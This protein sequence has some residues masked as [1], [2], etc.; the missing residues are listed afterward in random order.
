MV[1][2]TPMQ[3]V[4]TEWLI[5]EVEILDEI[6]V[7]LTTL[8]WTRRRLFNCLL[9][10]LSPLD[11]DFRQSQ[12]QYDTSSCNTPRNRFLPIVS[13]RNRQCAIPPFQIGGQPSSTSVPSKS[14]STP[15]EAHQPAQSL[16]P[17]YC[18]TAEMVS[19]E[20]L[21]QTLTNQIRLSTHYATLDK[22]FKPAPRNQSQNPST[23]KYIAKVSATPPRARN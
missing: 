23:D 13:N 7:T 10:I 16:P 18:E 21:P 5:T 6:A 11:L 2:T 9:N 20:F 8:N 22:R 15:R 1:R 4:T 3:P 12:C 17:L 19:S 14:V